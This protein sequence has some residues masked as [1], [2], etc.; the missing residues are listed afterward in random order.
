MYSGSERQTSQPRGSVQGAGAGASHDAGAGIAPGRARPGFWAGGALFLLAG[1]GS[2]P[3]SINPVAWW[4]E[5]QGGVIAEQRP[6]PP[7]AT[8]PYPNLA[9]VPPRPPPLD[10]A[11]RLAI[12]Q[13]L[14]ADRANAQHEAAAA[15]LADPSSP[16]QSPALFG[17]PPSLATV[18]PPSSAQAGA[19]QAGG[20]GAS[21]A[22]ASAPPVAPESPKR[23]KTAARAAP[24]DIPLGQ[25]PEGSTAQMGVPPPLPTAPPLPANLPGANPPQPPPVK[26]TP[27]P[28]GLAPPAGSVVV[29]F[30]PGAATLAPEAGATLHNLATQ[31]KITTGVVVTG[32]GDAA[33]SG[34]DTQA[35]ALSLA[36]LRAQAIVHA[37][38]AEG[39]PPAAIVSDAQAEGRGATV[40]LV[41]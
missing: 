5:L 3:A 7:G 16:T 35:A 1:C 25:Q 38:T 29:A 10:P 41:N 9:L 24:G 28:P 8:D 21:F 33:A 4:H 20:L 6:P 34:P 36:L 23:G 12:N 26:V 30:A 11:T 40:R 27:A 32:H 17:I 2:V 19:T 13:G 37:L 15:P 18:P 39:V 22:A 31:R 14:V